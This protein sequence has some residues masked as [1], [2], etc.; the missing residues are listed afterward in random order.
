MEVGAALE[1]VVVHG[2]PSQFLGV[3]MAEPAISAAER[4]AE[5]NFILTVLGGGMGVVDWRMW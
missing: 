3:A 1:V 5:A 4:R 2:L